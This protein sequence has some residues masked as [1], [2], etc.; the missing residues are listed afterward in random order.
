MTKL[1]FDKFG[2]KAGDQTGGLCVKVPFQI[3]MIGNSLTDYIHTGD[4]NRFNSVV[5]DLR[6]RTS[7][8][9][10]ICLRLRSTLSKRVSKDSMQSSVGHKVG[11]YILYQELYEEQTD[12]ATE[13]RPR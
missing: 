2:N 6:S 10:Q 4:L 9:V 8:D 13:N 1:D 12:G 3:E 7:R 11:T 5:A